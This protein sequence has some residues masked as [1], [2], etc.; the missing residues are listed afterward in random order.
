MTIVIFQPVF[1]KQETNQ[2]AL[3]AHVEK[4]K[5]ILAVYEAHL[6]VNKYLV[7][8]SITIA[9]VFHI[10]YAFYTIKKT[11]IGGTFITFSL[12]S[13]CSCEILAFFCYFYTLDSVTFI[14]ITLLTWLLIYIHTITVTLLT[15]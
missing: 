4:A 11:P 13:H 3:D 9:D 15:W 2:V 6:A 7:G 1:F 8:D 5:S 10:P 12:N 14:T